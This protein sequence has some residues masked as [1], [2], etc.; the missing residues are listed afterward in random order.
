MVPVARV[1]ALPNRC[2]DALVT[3]FGTIDSVA[4]DATWL[5][6]PASVSRVITIGDLTIAASPA[7][8]VEVKSVEVVNLSAEWHEI[9]MDFN[10]FAITENVNNPESTLLKLCADILKA[11]STDEDLGQLLNQ[12]INGISY[13]VDTD[14][15]ISGGHG[16]ALV[17]FTGVGRYDHSSTNTT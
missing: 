8:R 14:H 4:D 13:E 2:A 6:K 9:E 12:S 11:L 16:L 10:V 5:T 17:N 15:M 7:I 3:L 1:D